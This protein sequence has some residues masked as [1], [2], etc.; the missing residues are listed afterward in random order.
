L[1]TAP[2]VKRSQIFCYFDCC[3][4]RLDR[5]GLV[6]SSQSFGNLFHGILP[7]GRWKMPALGEGRQ[8]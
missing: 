2:L 1:P 6:F 3:L 4:K 5:L 8:C 7:R